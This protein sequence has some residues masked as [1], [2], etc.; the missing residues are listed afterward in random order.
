M[1]KLFKKICPL[2]AA[3]VLMSG[4]GGEPDKGTSLRI[5][6]RNDE[7]KQAFET[8]FGD[9]AVYKGKRVDDGFKSCTE[10]IYGGDCLPDGVEEIEIIVDED[11]YMSDDFVSY[12]NDKV[13][14]ASD[15][16]VDIFLTEPDYMYSHINSDMTLPLSSV[17]FKKRHTSDMFPYTVA[18]GTSEDGELKAVS[19]QAEPGVFLYR[20]DIALSV[21]GDDSP[22]TVSRLISEDFDGS[23]EKLGNAGYFIIASALD[24]YRTYS[25]NRT[26]NWLKD[27]EISVDP[28]VRQWT[29]DMRSLTEKGC[30]AGYSQWSYE[31]VNGLST[32][33]GGVFGYYLPVWA[34]EATLRDMWWEGGSG[35]W[36]VCMPPRPYC[37]G[38]SFLCV[39]SNTDNP[40]ASGEFLRK[41]CGSENMEKYAAENLN[42]GNSV[43]AMK[44]AADSEDFYS[45]FFGQNTYKIYFEAAKA[46]P[47]RQTEEYGELCEEYFPI[48]MEGYINGYESYEDCEESFIS[49]IENEAG[50]IE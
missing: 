14:A 6:C 44:K 32:E 2:I 40:R 28:V 8:L 39:S 16:P 1:K 49:H 20:R 7:F 17:G 15:D 31:W 12:I 34:C 24:A 43:K 26:E 46:V 18:L 3:A 42:F 50:G 30:I 13:S 27:G 9:K 48:D 47:Q 35:C 19:W 4:C 10:Y 23:A 5:L 41:L 25:Q 38:G 36:G 37:W 21:F 11:F 22:E 33:D 45:E 29:E